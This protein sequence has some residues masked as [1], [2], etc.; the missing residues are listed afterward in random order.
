MSLSKLREFVQA[1]MAPLDRE[2]MLL[3]RADIPRVLNA[4]TGL[5]VKPSDPMNRTSEEY[6]LALETELERGTLILGAMAR[7]L[8][9]IRQMR[10]ESAKTQQ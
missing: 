6:R 3:S 10:A 9:E 5:S 2:L 1:H 4:A 7:A 8:K